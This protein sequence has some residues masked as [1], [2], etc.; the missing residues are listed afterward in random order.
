MVQLT[1]GLNIDLGIDVKGPST[2]LFDHGAVWFA[3]NTNPD[4]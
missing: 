3:I 1:F 4:G 2:E